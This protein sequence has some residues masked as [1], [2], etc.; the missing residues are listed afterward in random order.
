VSRPQPRRRW[1]RGL[2]G[3][4][5]LILVVILVVR[6]RGAS[7]QWGVFFTTLQQV[8]WPWLILCV[9][10][11]LLTYFSRALRWEVMLRPFD[12]RVS[13]TRLT[14]DTAIGFM[15]AALLGRVGEMVRPYLISVSASVPFSSQVAAWF[16]ERLLDLMAVLLLFG[17]ALTRL[18]AHGDLGPGLRWSLGFGGYVATALGALCLLI[19]VL[20]R[21]FPAVAETRILNALR[22]LPD[23]YYQHSKQLLETFSRG[24]QA[25]RETAML[26]ALVLYTALQWAVI[27]G[28][29][30]A[31]FHMFTATS[32]LKS[33]D[34]VLILGFAAF[35]SLF[36]IP[37]I[38]GGT[39]ITSIVVLTEIY[40]LSFEVASGIAIFMWA[41]TLA[42]IVP[43]GLACAFHQGW[44]WRKI[45]RLAFDEL[46]KQE[47]L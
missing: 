10:L 43:F 19:L 6:I 44:N 32:K 11:M 15:A 38:G 22:F 13:V 2:V 24:V 7:F 18:P 5:I 9:L 23:N 14:S 30:Y 46:P 35:G 33:T 28:S 25:T 17:L 21:S 45:K 3:L 4:A 31:F 34:V 42:V 16:L 37:G 27:A 47:P 12:R 20:F 39:Q 40:G 1:R 36:Q 8:A 41:L 26:N 29:Y